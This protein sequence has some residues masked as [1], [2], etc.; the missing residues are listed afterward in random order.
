[1]LLPHNMAEVRIGREGRGLV[2]DRLPHHG[3]HGGTE[4]IVAGLEIRTDFGVLYLLETHRTEGTLGEERRKFHERKPICGKRIERIPQELFRARAEAIKRPPLLQNFRK[5]GHAD[6]VRR[7]SL[8]QGI[9]ADRDTRIGGL[10]QDQLVAQVPPKPSFPRI[11]RAKEERRRIPVQIEIQKPAISF[12]VLLREV[13]QERTLAGTGLAQD[14]NV[15]RAAH[16]AQFHVPSRYLTVHHPKS[17]IETP[18]L[19]PC[20]ATS[21]QEASDRRNELF[22]EREHGDWTCE[23]RTAEAAQEARPIA[24]CCKGADRTRGCATAGSS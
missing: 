23:R 1:M 3:L 16:I 8:L 18:T 6:K 14:R 24:L 7:R 13:P 22:N 4:R 11:D 21:A 19:L 5:L 17:E 20:S 10:N 12:D 15:H 9:Q 2:Q